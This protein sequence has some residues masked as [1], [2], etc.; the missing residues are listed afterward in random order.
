MMGPPWAT[1]NAAY[2]NLTLSCFHCFAFEIQEHHHVNSVCHL[3]VPNFLKKNKIMIIKKKITFNLF[4]PMFYTN[5]IKPFGLLS[6]HCIVIIAWNFLIDPLLNYSCRPLSTG[7]TI[8]EWVLSL[9][10]EVPFSACSTAA[11]AATTTT[12]KI[13]KPRTNTK[14]EKKNEGKKLQV[15]KG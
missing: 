15:Q 12:K 1:W 13:T 14:K 9:A 8:A 6:A 3:D 4:V 2:I 5:R 7:T 10:F 11:A